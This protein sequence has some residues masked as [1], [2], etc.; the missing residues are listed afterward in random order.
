PKTIQIS[1]SSIDKIYDGEVLKYDE[2]QQ[3]FFLV[4]EEFK[5]TPYTLAVSIEF[6][7]AEVFKL[8]IS[9]LNELLGSTSWENPVTITFELFDKNEPGKAAMDAEGVFLKNNYC[10]QIVPYPL[11]NVTP[12][13][14]S[15]QTIYEIKPIPIKIT[16]GSK[17]DYYDSDYEN[18]KD[19]LCENSYTVTE[20]LDKYKNNGGLME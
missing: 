8:S 14:N 10:L 13:P 4:D 12:D 18:G 16:A 7:T 9:E 3:Q 2:G 11:N 19:V 20:C 17:E 15:N 6:N 5:N 1:L